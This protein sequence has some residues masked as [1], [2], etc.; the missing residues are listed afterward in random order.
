MLVALE[1]G[2]GQLEI[3]LAQGGTASLFA[4]GPCCLLP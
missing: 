3:R 1:I 4:T 2:C